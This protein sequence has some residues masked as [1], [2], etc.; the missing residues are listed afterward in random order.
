MA[1]VLPDLQMSG[2]VPRFAADPGAQEDNVGLRSTQEKL[3]IEQQFWTHTRAATP[4]QL[5]LHT[6]PNGIHQ[7]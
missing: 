5:T 7:A 6:K 1:S 2:S 4:S 3:K